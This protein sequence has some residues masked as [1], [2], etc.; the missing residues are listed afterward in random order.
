MSS[1]ERPDRLWG[2]PGFL[3]SRYC[4]LFL[5]AQRLARRA[6]HSPSNSE[7]TKNGAMPSF[8]I[9]RHGLV[10]NE[11]YGKFNSIFPS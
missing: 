5:P 6:D 4:G 3:F 9:R 7:V 11:A 8:P 1:P 2:T 10:L